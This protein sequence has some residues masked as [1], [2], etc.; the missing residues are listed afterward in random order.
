MQ[1]KKQLTDSIVFFKTFRQWRHIAKKTTKHSFSASDKCLVIVPCDPWSVGGSR[2]DE[3]MIMGVIDYYLSLYHDMQ[4]F[5][6]CANDK[7]VDYINSLPIQNIN[8]I[9]SWNGS[10]PVERIYYSICDVYPSDV[11]VLGADCMD[12][13]YS[14]VLS[15]SL[16]AIYDLCNKTVGINSYLLGFSLNNNPSWLMRMAFKSVSSD[17]PIRLRDPMS[18]QRYKKLIGNS[19][20]LVADAAFLLRPNN[21]F[22]LYDE[23][24]EWVKKQRDGGKTIIGVNFHP[25]LRKYTGKEEIKKDAL[26]VAKNIE[27]ILLAHKDV[28]LVFIPHDNRSMLTDNLML[29]TMYAY[30]HDKGLTDRVF[31]SSFVPRSSQLKAICGLLD[32]IISSRMHLA[33]AAL[34]M[35]IPVMAATYQGKFEGLFMHFGLD[36]KYLLSPKEFL[37][38][39]MLD[40]FNDFMSNLPDLQKQITKQLPNVLKL[41][42]L[43]LKNV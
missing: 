4:I 2:G 17:L 7:G 42:I 32:G 38:D 35:G 24:C 6:V 15:E 28:D 31:Y 11:V 19:A 27:N 34:G 22:R 1:L 36:P 3:A 8:P 18:F 16:L 21:K 41:S 39:D 12:G 23:I 5:I 30:L 13:Y 33:I 43:N 26:I 40:V 37:S 25:M 9:V 14:P 29:T 20:N 10:Y